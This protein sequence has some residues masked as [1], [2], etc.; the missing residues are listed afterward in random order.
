MEGNVDFVQGRRRKKDFL[1]FSQESSV[2]C[3]DYLEAMFS[4]NLQEPLQLGMA[5]GLTHQ[6]EIE[7]I[8]PGTQLGKDLGKGILLHDIGLS[9][10]AGAET[11]LQIADIGDFQIDFTKPFHVH[12]PSF[13]FYIIAD[14]ASDASVPIDP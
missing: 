13:V 9:P 4:G 12:P 3:Q 14:F 6:M 10:C 5:E 1:L 2:G 8:G 11:A 7:K